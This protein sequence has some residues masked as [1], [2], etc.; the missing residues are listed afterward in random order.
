MNG[1]YLKLLTSNYVKLKDYNGEEKYFMKSKV[2][3]K[4]YQQCQKKLIVQ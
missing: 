3:V 1:Q 4:K 2:S